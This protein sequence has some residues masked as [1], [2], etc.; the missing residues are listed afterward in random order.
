MKR[1]FICSR[2]R[3]DERHSLKQNIRRASLGCA[4]AMVRGYAPIAPHLMYLH[5]LDDNVPF[6]R[7]AGIRAGLALLPVCDELWQWGAT[8]SEGMAMEIALAKKLDIP[9][10]IFNSLGI[11]KERWNRE[12]EGCST[13]AKL[14]YPSAPIAAV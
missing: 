11:P 7:E 6:D 8:V 14:F 4:T 12:E 13:T 10:R 3:P 2:L 1:V 5:F 9:I